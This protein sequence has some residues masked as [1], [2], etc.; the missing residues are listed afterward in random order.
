MHG[1]KDNIIPQ[2]MGLELFEKAK[3][4]GRE[5]VIQVKGYVIERTSK[6]PNIQTGEIKVKLNTAVSK[7]LNLIIKC[8]IKTP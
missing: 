7:Q 5:F 1:K 4:L 6:N 2:N 8:K 3:T